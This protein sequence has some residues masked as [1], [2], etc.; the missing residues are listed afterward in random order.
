MFT[1]SL[2]AQTITTP[3]VGLELPAAGS[4]N[5]NLPLNYNF[6]LLDQLLG[7]LKTSGLK[8]A[9]QPILSLGSPSAICNANNKGQMDFDTTTSPWTQYACDGISSWHAVG[10]SGGGGG[11]ATFPTLP[12]IV[13]NT[14]TLASR[15]AV[16]G[17][18]VGLWG[19]CTGYLKSDGT[20]SIPSPGTS[21]TVTPDSKYNR[22]NGMYLVG[23]STSIGG[24]ITLS[25]APVNG[26]GSFDC[27]G[28]ANANWGQTSLRLDV[29]PYQYFN[30]DKTTSTWKEGTPL[31][32]TVEMIFANFNQQSTQPLSTGDYPYPGTR[33]SNSGGI[34]NSGNA[35][36]LD[37]YNTQLYAWEDPADNRQNT[38]FLNCGI[39][40]WLNWAHSIGWGTIADGPSTI[41]GTIRAAVSYAG[42]P[43]SGRIPAQSTSSVTTSG[44]WTNFDPTNSSTTVS[45]TWASGAASGSITTPGSIAH[46]W[47]VSDTTNPNSI[48][49]GTYV[50]VITGSAVTL[51]ASTTAAITGDTLLFWNP[52]IAP[53]RAGY[54]KCGTSGA[55][56]E[57]T[58]MPASGALDFTYLID[59]TPGTATANISIDGVAA[60]SVSSGDGG[61]FS[62]VHYAQAWWAKRFLLVGTAQHKFD[63][64]VTSGSFCPIEVTTPKPIGWDGMSQPKVVQSIMP[65]AGDGYNGLDNLISEAQVSIINEL[66]GDGYN[67]SAADLWGGWPE[68]KGNLT[69]GFGFPFCVHHACVYKNGIDGVYESSP[70]FNVAGNTLNAYTNLQAA[71]RIPNPAPNLLPGTSG[72]LTVDK[73]Q[74]AAITDVDATKVDVLTNSNTHS[75]GPQN[76][77]TGGYLKVGERYYAVGNP[78]SNII[79]NSGTFTGG[80]A[81]I[82]VTAGRSLIVIMDNASVATLS[83]GEATINKTLGTGGGFTVSGTAIKNVVG[84]TE[85]L[86]I[87]PAASTTTWIEFSNLNQTTPF[88]ASTAFGVLPQF[89]IF[90]KQT[91][92]MLITAPGDLLISFSTQGCTNLSNATS[93]PPWTAPDGMT[94]FVPSAG[95]LTGMRVWTGVTPPLGSV[96]YTLTP[97]R[98]CTSIDNGDR[99]YG[100][101]AVRPSFA[102]NQSAHVTEWVDENGVLQSWVDR[103]GAPGGNLAAGGTPTASQIS[104]AQYAASTNTA[105]AYS[106]TLSPTIATYADGLTVRFLPSA[107]NTTTTPTINVNG[108]GAS[109]VTLMSGSAVAAGDLSTS[110][111]ASVVRKGTTWQ[112]Q[113]P[114]VS[115]G[116][117]GSGTAV[118]HNGGSTEATLNISGMDVQVCSDSSGSGTAQS[119]NTSNVYTL[120]SGNC[121]VYKTTTTNSGTGLTINPNGSGAKPVAVP[122]SSGWTTTLTASL[123]PTGK[124]LLTCYDGTNLNIQQTGVT[125]ASTAGTVPF[126]TDTSG[127]TTTYVIP[128]TS[129]TVTSLTSG[130]T[131]LARFGGRNTSSTPTLNL[132]GLGAK[133]IVKGSGS[134]TRPLA[135]ADINTGTT[136]LLSYDAGSTTWLLMNPNTASLIYNDITNSSF[137]S[138]GV[139]TVCGSTTIFSPSA[140]C[141]NQDDVSG[142]FALGNAG[143]GLNVVHGYQAM[144]NSNGSALQTVAYGAFA[145]LN[146]NSN[147]SGY[148]GISAGSNSVT[149][150][151]QWM[152]G[153]GVTDNC[154]N[155]QDFGNSA[156]TITKMAGTDAKPTQTAIA[157]ATTIAPTSPVFHVTGTATV[158]TITPPTGCTAAGWSCK[159]MIIPD[160]AF[161]TATGGNIALAT[162]AVVNRVLEMIYDPGTSL[163]Y[164]SY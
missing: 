161:L 65:P 117:G 75:T 162:T 132:N 30:C 76:V 130:L 137:L 36:C 94:T 35:A 89:I 57:F 79:T 47:R 83:G 77:L 146:N 19:S 148:F 32:S 108:I 110:A 34:P 154:S 101:F 74:S 7:G 31:N 78:N 39:G 46:Y 92:N 61:A 24:V 44:T 17:D 58:T 138:A 56:M 140:S 41:V 70:H 86:T 142:V 158:S 134:N 151:N 109:T 8:L 80:S 126:G 62:T 22:G 15:N 145:G 50:T 13:W 156:I 16:F 125:T 68:S 141:F 12:G 20:C 11:G 105:D 14:T 10:G 120:A 149:Q 29:T 159:I 98:H 18:I 54:A 73:T 26:T 128:S 157:S 160:G 23:D 72:L 152:W 139:S 52:S 2:S 9:Y 84:G 93:T 118:N 144:R 4:T 163:W 99:Y 69:P 106:V 64:T 143:G 45:G 87:S 71:D 66:K 40:D 3:N 113:N 116:G 28:P 133:T 42:T 85:T 164:P 53:F 6:N 49:S 147:N 33:Y 103:A 104:G 153:N 90:Q 91:E 135:G 59:G 136:Y 127:S 82:S 81:A 21:G 107:S 5:W 43:R 51:S 25:G 124:P 63:V 38:Y 88:E 129:P 67:I 112:L 100:L 119:C 123:I 114:Q 115:S 95:S 155:C 121:F 102:A 60:G 131:I 122:G 37:V 55:V 1:I 96:N 27:P 150:S 111:V 97:G 48:P